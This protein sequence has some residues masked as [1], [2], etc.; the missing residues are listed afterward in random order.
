MTSF[1]LSSFIHLHLIVTSQN[2]KES[3]IYTISYSSGEAITYLQDGLISEYSLVSKKPTK[4][5]YVNPTNS[6]IYFHATASDA[7]QLNKLDVK[8]FA[9]D[10]P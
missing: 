8:M 4:F 9:L 3:A 5:M 2:P 7:A 1:G 10:D 6:P